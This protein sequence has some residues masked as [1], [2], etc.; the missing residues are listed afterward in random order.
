M[1]EKQRKQPI[2]NKRWLRVCDE[3]IREMRVDFEVKR[4]LLYLV[5]KERAGNCNCDESHKRGKFCDNCGKKIRHIYPKTAQ[6]IIQD[7]IVENK[8]QDEKQISSSESFKDNTFI[9]SPEE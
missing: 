6:N 7:Q 4:T 5:W 1:E 3:E 8:R 2:L 9:S